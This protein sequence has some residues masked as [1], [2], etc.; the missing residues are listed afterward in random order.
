MSPEQQEPH[1]AIQTQPELLKM[2]GPCFLPH[3]P[4]LLHFFVVS[5]ESQNSQDGLTA[6][7]CGIFSGACS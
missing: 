7:G 2:Y 3:P 1:L 6:G 4:A 5:F